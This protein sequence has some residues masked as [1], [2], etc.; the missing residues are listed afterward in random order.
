MTETLLERADIFAGGNGNT[1]DEENENQGPAVGNGRNE[2]G[3]EVEAKPTKN[4]L[5]TLGAEEARRLLGITLKDTP[6]GDP[7]QNGNRQSEETTFTE[8]DP[9]GTGSGP[10]PSQN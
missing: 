10:E 8:E 4:F 6:K 3:V 5:T 7:S 9:T 2:D 1:E